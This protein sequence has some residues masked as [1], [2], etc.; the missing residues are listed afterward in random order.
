MEEEQEISNEDVKKQFEELSNK[1]D[2]ETSE[3]SSAEEKEIPASSTEDVKSETGEENVEEVEP[4]VIPYERFKERNERAKELEELLEQGKDFIV[5]DPI[6]GKLTIKVPEKEE[7]PEV[8]D[9]RFDLTEEESIALDNVQISVVQKLFN[10]WQNETTKQFEEQRKY[11]V[12]TDSWWKKCQ[13]DYPEL[14]GENFKELPIYKKAIEIL[15]D[16][17]TVWSKDKKSFYIPPNAQY[18]SLVQAEKEL[19]RDKVKTSQAK[20]EEKKTQKQ[21]VFVEKKSGVQQAKKKMDEKEFEESDSQTQEDALRAQF[22]ESKM[23]LEE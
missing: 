7:K 1:G 5:K 20:I 6:T 15:K 23:A 10:K 9:K 17:H 2:V 16:Q 18:L 3:E 21:Q 22:E 11:A 19:S 12:E 8:E 13:G 4:K 14:K